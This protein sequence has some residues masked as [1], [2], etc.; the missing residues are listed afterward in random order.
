MFCLATLVDTT[1]TGP[2]WLHETKFDGYRVMLRVA[3][4]TCRVVTRGGHDWTERF[5]TIAAAA[6]KL[7]ATSAMID[8]EVVAYDAHGRSRFDLLQRVL[9][10]EVD[11]PLVF[12]AFDLIEQDG[13]D[14]R[15]LSLLERK[16]ALAA[17]FAR[18]RD[19]LRLTTALDDAG[20]AA[21]KRACKRGLEGLVSKRRD[22][23]Y[24]GGRGFD[25]VKSKCIGRQEFVIGGYSAPRG[26]RVGFGALLL[27]VYDGSKLRYAG[28]VG[29]GFS[30]ATMSTLA[31]QLRGMVQ[32]ESAFVDPP[33]LRA[34][35]W[36]EPRLACEVAFTAWTRDGRLR[37]PTFIG[38]REDKDPHA[39]G[40]E[41]ARSGPRE[42]RNAKS[43]AAPANGAETHRSSRRSVGT[44]A[45]TTHLT[46]ADKV[47][48]PDAGVTKGDLARYFASIAPAMLPY[49][50][51]RPLALVR[52]PD[53]VRKECFFQKHAG[54]GR[55][56]IVVHDARE[57][58]AL[59]QLGAI[60]I[61]PW[62]SKRSAL[63]RPDVLV[64]DLDPSP[65]VPWKDVVALAHAIRRLLEQDGLVSYAKLTGG[66]GIHVVAP[67]R[68][69]RDWAAHKRWA[70][71]IAERVVALAPDRLT[72]ALRRAQRHGRIFIDYLRNGRGATAVAPYS[73]RA[74]AGAPVACPVRWSELKP[75]LR[76]D[77]FGFD[78]AIARAK[79]DPWRGYSG[80]S[81]PP[82]ARP[83]AQPKRR[84]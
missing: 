6:A 61:H 84:K 44:L 1:P 49:I 10:G 5:Q 13:A 78:A 60:E 2:Q 69:T 39:I 22:A 81:R 32:D 56:P 27:G 15:P 65:G 34:V 71:A 14:L 41:R 48:F 52:C 47:L 79:R 25:W 64:L 37:H 57:L 28:K 36:V 21:W 43:S 26:A 73:P 54:P 23:P 46:H 72:I 75:S 80:P 40:R 83:P 17:L 82:R 74:R 24:H 11:R 42:A 20:P 63:E 68:G 7:R 76:P 45:E 12:Q 59:A 4:G 29:T 18:M 51:D 70:K 16:D 33:R 30:T 35:H 58:V 9:A 50:V 66:K 3:D 62:G 55:G 67:T 77:A 38:M 19:P 8:G 31:K 53:G